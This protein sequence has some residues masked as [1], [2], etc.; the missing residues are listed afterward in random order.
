MVDRDPYQLEVVAPVFPVTNL[1]KALDHY[2]NTLRFTVKFEWADADGE[3]TRYAILENG[4]CELHLSRGSDPQP[5]SAYIFVDRVSAYYSTVRERGAVISCDIEDQPWQMREFE[6]TD[7][8][9]NRLVFGEHL[10]RIVDG[11]ET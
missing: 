11:G 7:P 1:A 5:T 4:R 9:G 2:V 8:D 6:V 3:P 10:S